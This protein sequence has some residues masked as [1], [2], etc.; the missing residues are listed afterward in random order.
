MHYEL[1]RGQARCDTKIFEHARI[2]WILR[3]GPAK[4][5]FEIRPEQPIDLPHLPHCG[6]ALASHENVAEFAED[7]LNCSSMNVGIGSIKVA[8]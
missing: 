4:N 6:L 1:I 3:S 5:I 2:E 7:T 8:Q